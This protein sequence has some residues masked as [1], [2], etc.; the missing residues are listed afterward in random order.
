M[1]SA[2][3]ALILILTAR[4]E[5]RG[6]CLERARLATVVRTHRRTAAGREPDEVRRYVMFL[7]DQ[8]A[9]REEFRFWRE[10]GRIHVAVGTELEGRCFDVSG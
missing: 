2:R 4:A 9:G 3:F 6:S 1:P 7:N 8:P 5:H 10:D